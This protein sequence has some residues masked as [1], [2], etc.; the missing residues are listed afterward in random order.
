MKNKRLKLS[1]EQSFKMSNKW[2]GVG[3]GVGVG[4]I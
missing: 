3:V 2:Q 1:K 4:E